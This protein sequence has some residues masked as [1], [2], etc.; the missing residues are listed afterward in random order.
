MVA[1]RAGTAYRMSMVAFDFAPPTRQATLDRPLSPYAKLSRHIWRVRLGTRLCLN[2]P[3]VLSL[4]FSSVIREIGFQ[5][6]TT[7][8]KSWTKKRLNLRVRGSCRIALV[9]SHFRTGSSNGSQNTSSF[10]TMSRGQLRYLLSTYRLI[11]NLFGL[12]SKGSHIVPAQ[13]CSSAEFLS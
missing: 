6:V 9:L 10:L 7:A 13:L 1:T 3:A 11:H 8:M 2:H 5:V 4:L 12:F